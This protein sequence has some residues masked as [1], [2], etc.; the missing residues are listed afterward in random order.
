MTARQKMRDL[1]LS[2]RMI[3]KTPCGLIEKV[4][5]LAESK[6]YQLSTYLRIEIMKK[7]A[8]YEKGTKTN[9]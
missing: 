7:L 9:D 5:K 6:G 2:E 8:E 4:H 3:V 1:K